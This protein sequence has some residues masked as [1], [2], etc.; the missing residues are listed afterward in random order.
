[1]QNQDFAH[2][3]LSCV[4]NMKVS[5]R[6]MGVSL[7]KMWTGVQLDVNVTLVS[8]SHHSLHCKFFFLTVFPTFPLHTSCVPLC[9]L[10]D[11]GEPRQHETEDQ[12]Q[13]FCRCLRVP[14][15]LRCCSLTF[16]FTHFRSILFLLWG[17]SLV[18]L[19]S[20]SACL[21]KIVLNWEAAVTLAGIWLNDLVHP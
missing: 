18:P 11:M 5:Q 21:Q 19:S 1:M 4:F 6:Q 14:L 15:S 17:S 20:L 3:L 10:V 2:V 8:P 12:A 13:Q 16:S 7:L 9:I